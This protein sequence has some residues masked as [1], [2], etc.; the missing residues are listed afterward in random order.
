MRYYK[1]NGCGNDFI[2]INNIEEHIPADQVPHLA[3]TLCTRRMSIGADGLMVVEK[4]DVADFKMI[5]YNCD[6]SV[7]EMCGNGARCICR[8]AFAVGLSG[9]RQTVETDSGVITGERLTERQY[10]I[11]MTK[12]THINTSCEVSA[13]GKKIP[14]SYIE[15]GAPPLPHAVVH[16]PDVATVDEKWL[17]ALGKEIR[18][19]PAFPNGANVNFYDKTG[20]DAVYIRT[21]E[22]GVEDFTFACGSGTVSTALALYLNGELPSGK[23]IA[24]MRGGRLEVD[25]EQTGEE[26]SLYLTGPTN[27]VACGEVLDE[28]LTQIK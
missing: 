1:I 22:R 21:F 18:E 6:G 10:K 19:S 13:D 12:P 8:Y 25:V 7:G 20:P 2:I 27:I 11:E 14:C 23:L 4:S 16:M 15:L 24:D 9:P 26:F 3:K 28:E 17:F 5:Y